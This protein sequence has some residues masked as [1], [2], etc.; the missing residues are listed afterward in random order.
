MRKL[1]F[2]LALAFPLTL[3]AQTPVNSEIPEWFQKEMK[4]RVGTWIASNEEYKGEQEPYDSYGMEWKLGTGGNSMTGTLY[5]II[6]GKNTVPFW[7]FRTFWHPVD[8]KVYAYQFGY[9]GAVGMGE[10]LPHRVDQVFYNPDGTVSRSGHKSE[11]KDGKHIASSFNIDA[12]GKW[13]PR[14]SYTWTKEKK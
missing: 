6:D 3:V 9:G 10:M 1:K 2:M 14:R 8:K 12:D 7:E 11:D 5:G 4:I 13:T